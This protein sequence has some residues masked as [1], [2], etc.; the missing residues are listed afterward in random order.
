MR[1]MPLMPRVRCA[2]IPAVPP[3]ATRTSPS[4]GPLRAARLCGRGTSYPKP[5]ATRRGIMSVVKTSSVP[6]D[7]E[8]L[9]ANLATTAQEVVIPDRYL[10]LLEAVDGLHGVRAALAETMGEYFHT[11]RNADL[12][13]DGFQTTLLRNWSY[14]ERS[15]RTARELFGLLGGAGRRPS[16]VAAD[17]R[18]V[19]A[20]APGA[21]HLVHGRARRAATADEYDEA[22]AGLAGALARLLPEHEAE[23]LERDTLLRNLTQR[24]SRASGARAR[25]TRRSSARS[26]P[27]GTAACA[28]AS[29]SRRGRSRRASTSPTPGAVAGQFA[30]LTG[31]RLVDAARRAARGAGRPSA[32]ARRSRC[33]RRSWRRPSTPC[34]GSRTWRTGSPSASSSSRTRRWATGRRRSWP[35]SSA[36]SSR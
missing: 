2:A 17:R 33:S 35:T 1:P 20:A 24:A 29:T 22:L 6:F 26:S 3:V 13:V 11:F 9:R 27:P 7:S 23:F 12:L 36:W 14:F 31:R 4:D 18:P 5:P 10:P 30:F 28:T 15:P 21:A 16:R 19:L 34:S 32:H 25:R 8:A